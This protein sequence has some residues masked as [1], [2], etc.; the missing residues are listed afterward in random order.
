MR[1]EWLEETSS[2]NTVALESQEEGLVVVA[3]RQ[4]AGR[5][6]HGRRWESAPGLGLWFSIALRGTPQGLN[7]AAP[8]A[9]R[10]ALAPLVPV[11]I[12]W[13][14][15]LLVDGRKLCGILVEHRAGW[16]ALGI[17]L[18]VNHAPG[19]FPEELRAIATSLRMVTGKEQDRRAL[20]D[21]I[22]AAL[23]PHLEHWR[24]GRIDA[25]YR[26]WSEAC[27]IIGQP[28]RRDGIEGV[29]EG[30]REDGALLVR[31]GAGQVAVTG[32]EGW[33]QGS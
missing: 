31:T 4:T 29:A 24:S 5:G 27:G 23:A 16:N 10:E 3:D 25:I 28:I 22:L 30:I 11:R 32:W 9:L 33:E 7:F 6:Q 26:A 12:K 20:L 21:A 13:P 1:I 2:T 14:N 15:D 8:L 17:G 18:N 19:D